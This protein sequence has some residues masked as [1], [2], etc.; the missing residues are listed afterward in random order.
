MQPLGRHGILMAACCGLAWGVPAV[1]AAAGI[2]AATDR[3]EASM[4]DQLLLTVTVEGS[5]SAQPTLPDLSMFDVE[6]RGQTTQVQIVNGHMSTSSGYNFVLVPKRA[7]RF[8]IGPAKVTIDGQDYASEPFVVS[9][10]AAPAAAPESAGSALFTTAEVSTETPFV[11]QQVTF[12]WRFFRRV[13]IGNASIAFPSFDG[14]VTQDLGEKREYETTIKG[15]QY[16]VTEVK[17]ALFPQ[18]AGTLHLGATALNVEVVVNRQRRGG[19]NGFFNSPFDDMFDMGQREAKVLR[20]NPI[21]IKVQPL[22]PPPPGFDGQVGEFSIEGQLSQNAVTVGESTTLTLTVTGVGNVQHLP[23]PKL[24]EINGF[25]VYDDKPTGTV[26]VSGN[27]LVGRKIFKKALVPTVP[28]THGI[29]PVSIVY[30]DPSARA[31]KTAATPVFT[32][33]VAPGV[34]REDPRL[35]AAAPLAGAPAGKRDVQVLAD[36]L[37]PIYK[38]ADAL[39]RWPPPTWPVG[40]LF[41]V[42]WLFPPGLFTALVLWRRRH[43][44]AARDA[45]E[46]RRRTALRRTLK[47]VGTVQGALT[48]GKTAEAAALVSRGMR[49]YLGDKLGLEGLALTPL[50]VRQVLET[51]GAD[52]A[53]ARQVEDLLGSC[54]AAQYGAGA[55]QLADASLPRDMR[56]LLTKLDQSL[57]S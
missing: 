31:Y 15:Q 41:T 20:T 10:G 32:L 27:T 24:P 23:E 35:T 4:E 9:I 48:H 33:Q 56:T 54:D 13:R 53:L 6:S 22:P 29:G 49:E 16:L 43:G 52:G 57:R 30:F 45:Q 44:N 46:R 21:D 17:K 1:A 39:T 47:Q 55:A 11:S 8:T 37:L 14:F 18:Q 25:K 12:T 3:T 50:E 34:G 42:A 26:G 51:R 19:G 40:W 28:G 36:D 38:R 5:R 7:G 2:R